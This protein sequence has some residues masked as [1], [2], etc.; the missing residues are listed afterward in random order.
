MALNNNHS[1]PELLNR[2]ESGRFDALKSDSTH[3]FFRND[4]IKSGSL[5]FSQ[6]SGC[7][8]ILSVYI[9]MSFNF[10]FVRL[11]LIHWYSVLH[12]ITE[13]RLNLRLFPF[14]Q[15]CLLSISPNYSITYMNNRCRFAFSLYNIKFRFENI[16]QLY[17]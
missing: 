16:I 15:F 17:I 2:N 1:Q 14:V 7:W 6:F 13:L 9:L 10:P 3:H 5:R 11:F 12:G 4:C 8:L